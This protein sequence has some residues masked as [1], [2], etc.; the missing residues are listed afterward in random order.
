MVDIQTLQ[1]A[2]SSDKK[3][4]KLEEEV[5]N[6][7]VIIDKII[8][9]GNNLTQHSNNV[10]ENNDKLS[11]AWNNLLQ[12]LDNKA[13]Q[14]KLMLTAQ[15]FLFEVVEVEGWIKDKAESMKQAEFGKDEDSSIK[16]LTKHK[17]LELEIDT[18]SGITKEISAS[19]SKLINNNHPDS[20]KIKN[21]DEMLQRE[22]KNLQNL[23]KS[24]RDKLILTI[25]A[26][27]YKRESEDFL[28]WISDMMTGARSEEVGQDYEH[29]ELLL[30]KFQDFKLRVQAGEEKFAVCESLAKRIDNSD[31]HGQG[32]KELQSK[33][34]D[35]WMALIEAIQVIINSNWLTLKN[36]ISD[37]LTQYYTDL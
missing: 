21:K 24:R 33:I 5:K 15:Q 32:V 17:A 27:E 12:A 22:M 11:Q 37:W 31:N 6:H 4:K 9:C 25:Q 3:H 7:S 28:S 10:M 23:S 29:H 30:A 26:H 14:L 13:S 36:L 19:A 2:Q 35:E 8:D 20:K 1:Q 16:F 18:Y 34:S